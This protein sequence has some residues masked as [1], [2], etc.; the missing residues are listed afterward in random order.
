MFKALDENNNSV[1][2]ENAVQGGKYFCPSCGE[3]VIIKAKISLAIK[4]HFS[5][6]KGT[7]C[8]DFTHDMSEWHFNW[9]RQ[10]PEECREVVVENE[11]EKHRAD[12]LIKNVVIE[13]QHSPIT[14]D[15]IT[16]R[17]NFYMSCGYKVIWVFDAEG[18]IKNEF[19][20]TLDPAK[21][22]DNDLCWKR[23]KQQFSAPINPNVSVFIEYKTELSIPSLNGQKMDILLLL[24]TVDPKYFSFYTTQIGDKYF[25][26]TPRNLV[27]EFNDSITDVEPVSQIVN[28]AINY[29]R[30]I[31]K[32][33][34]QRKVVYVPI[35]R[36][37]KYRRF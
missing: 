22:R 10:F 11:K 2:I 16:R 33:N 32:L 28:A 18:K 14:A 35:Y 5:H 6:K 34:S 29:K 12:V 21:C 4:A 9:Q 17:N 30:Q 31:Q 37:R 7:D 23:A 36:G 25:Y 24:K 27:R 26:L 20:E 15:E 8:D 1:L 19:E 3:Q 13:F